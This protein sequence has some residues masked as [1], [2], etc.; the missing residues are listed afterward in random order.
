MVAGADSEMREGS[1]LGFQGVIG[2]KRHRDRG[3]AGMPSK[4][5]QQSRQ[6]LTDLRAI[7]EADTDTFDGLRLNFSQWFD[8]TP[9]NFGAL[10]SPINGAGDAD[11]PLRNDQLTGS[12]EQIGKHDHFRGPL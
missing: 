8:L 9:P 5:V 10:I 3:T 2:S 7:T 4:D 1:R 12:P 11:D 6:L